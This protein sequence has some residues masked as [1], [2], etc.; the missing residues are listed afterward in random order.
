MTYTLDAVL[1]RLSSVEKKIKNVQCVQPLTSTVD[2]QTELMTSN[3]QAADPVKPTSSTTQL[4]Q[5][6]KPKSF[7]MVVMTMAQKEIG[8]MSKPR[9]TMSKPCARLLVHRETIN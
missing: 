1:Q 8:S 4:D 2:K 9:R 3:A 5:P 7:A 6:D